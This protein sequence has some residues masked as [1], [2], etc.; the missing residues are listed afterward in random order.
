MPDLAFSSWMHQRIWFATFLLCFKSLQ[1]FSLEKQLLSKTVQ[2][3][4]SMAMRDQ[5]GGWGGKEGDRL[6]TLEVMQGRY[7]KTLPAIGKQ[8]QGVSTFLLGLEQKGCEYSK[9]K[10]SLISTRKRLWNKTAI[11]NWPQKTPPSLIRCSGCK[12]PLI[13]LGLKSRCKGTGE[14]TLLLACGSWIMA[15]T[16][17]IPRVHS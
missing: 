10:G 4:S 1:P 8:L 11:A 9:P 5:W 2:T 16:E 14:D 17:S 12:K 13:F 15:T 7:G 3:M 6:K